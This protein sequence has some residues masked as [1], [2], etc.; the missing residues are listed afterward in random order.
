MRSS[1]GVEPQAQSPRVAI[2][3]DWLTG[4]RGG[5]RVLEGLLDIFPDA[6]LHTLVHV[7]G[8]VSPFIEDRDIVTSF[9]DWLPLS[10]RKHQIYLP[11][12]PLAV[13]GLQLEGAD[14]V[15]STSHCVAKGALAPP[16]VP[17]ICYCHTP[18]R[19]VWGFRDAYFAQ[20]PRPV[21]FFIERILDLLQN[22]DVASACRVDGWITNSHNVAGRLRSYYGVDS[23]VIYP[24]VDV[25]R[26]EFMGPR[27]RDFYL[28]VSAL[29]PYKRIDL[30]VQAASRLPFPLKIVGDG[31]ERRRLESLSGSNVTFLGR[32]PDREVTSLMQHARA[33][34]FPGEEDFGIT[35]VEAQAAGDR[36]S[37]V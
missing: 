2:V 8:S 4:M 9:I 19:Y 26:F 33:F 23:S 17:H 10:H 5:E 36:K 28:V 35:P 3:H 16:G 6:S 13:R 7:P 29:V 25:D 30:V 37:V 18:M 32:L 1:D 11:L 20:Q 15:I 34:I 31:P 22:W 21:R 24:P 27:R 14:L 12:F